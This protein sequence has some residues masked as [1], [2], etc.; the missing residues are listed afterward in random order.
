MSPHPPEDAPKPTHS[1]DPASKRPGFH[2]TPSRNWMND[3]TGMVFFDGEYH[4][5]FQHNPHGDRW[6]HMS[7]GHAVS[8]DLLAWT[9]LPLALAERDGVMAFSGSAIVDRDDASGLG[10]EG[11][12]ALVAIYTAHDTRTGVQSQHLAF[13]RDGG[14]TWS[15]LSA[16]PVLDIGERD[17]RDPKVFWHEPSQRF[18]MAVAWP[19]ERK[20]RFYASRD[21]K[22]WEHLSDFGPAGATTGIWECPDLFPLACEEG[23]ERAWVL[24]VSTNPG[25]P[26]G[27]SGCQYFVGEFDGHRF[28]E[29]EESRGSGPLWLDHGPDFYATVTWSD[30]PRADGRRIALGWMSNWQYAQEVPTT[31][32]RGAM[33]LPRELGLRRTAAGLRVVQ[34]PVREVERLRIEPPQRFAGGPF[35]DAAAW[36][37]GRLPLASRFDLEISFADIAPRTRFALELRC[38][39]RE[40]TII[41]FD[42]ELRRLSI[43]RTNSGRTD[44]HPAFAGRFEAPVE[45]DARRLSL[46]LIADHG[47]L[48]LFAQGGA[49]AQT[50]LVFPTSA[51]RRLALSTRS[52]A[53]PRV[54]AI[55]LRALAAATSVGASNAAGDRHTTATPGD[56][57]GA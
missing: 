33:T 15:R 10:G 41:A 54:E 11:S 19:L 13:S 49:T 51:E 24:L 40:R 3:P 20:V 47:S 39:S 38:G 4:L 9:E 34:Q 32:W 21:L 14:R 12:A 25:G 23:R 50:L 57:R 2:F 5:C 43:D 52:D 16:N 42:A 44:F 1:A 27:G 45:L 7:W 6:G 26:A 31:P 17:F 8:R 18:V 36:L 35:D 53:T 37:E 22:R 30:V 29:A 48:E 56:P 55:T 46:R 28:V